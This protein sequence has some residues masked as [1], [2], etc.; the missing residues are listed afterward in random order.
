M[1]YALFIP[2]PLDSRDF[3][4][5]HFAAENGEQDF[6]TLFPA[7]VRFILRQNRL[8]LCGGMR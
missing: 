2:R 5:W 8:H 1:R 7:F 3:L 4:P 6:T